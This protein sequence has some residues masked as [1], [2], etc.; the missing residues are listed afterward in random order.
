MTARPLRLISWILDDDELDKTGGVTGWQW[1][2]ASQV[3]SKWVKV[4]LPPEN[5][6]GS[7]VWRR[8][9]QLG[10]IVE[11]I[12]VAS[13]IHDN[14]LHRSRPQIVLQQGFRQSF[15][16][17]VLQW[18]RTFITLFDIRGMLGQHIC[19]SPSLNSESSASAVR[20]SCF[21]TLV[22]ATSSTDASTCALLL[23]RVDH[24]QICLPQKE[25]VRQ[26]H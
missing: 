2:G 22:V 6:N 15:R 14:V 25:N 7:D 13:L 18:T 11:M 23:K 5:H 8:Q 10:H 16:C 24:I 17:S 26:S 12:H 19:K 9:A 1:S 21:A 20:W 3:G 4:S